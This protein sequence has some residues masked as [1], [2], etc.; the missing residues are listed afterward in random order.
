MSDA[1]RSEWTKLT[2]LRSTPWSLVAVVFVTVGLSGLITLGTH[3]DG[4]PG[5]NVACDDDLVELALSGVYLGQ[6]AAATLG[7]LAIGAEFSSGMIRATFA[8]T[9][10]RGHVLMAKALVI[11]GLVLVAGL[12]SSLLAYVLGLAVL[13][14]NGYTPANGYPDPTFAEALRG[15]AGT[16]VY[17][18]ALALLGLGVGAILRRTAAALTTVFCLLW[19]P[20]IV[21][22]ILPMDLGLKIARFCPML[23]GLAIQSTVTRPDDIPIAPGAGLAVICGYAAVALLAGAWL[24][25]RRDA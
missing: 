9:P 21:V 11:G 15:V 2:A 18:A 14:A 23:A 1:L 7:V 17:L 6:M 10:R 12:L 22:S 13:D 16:G 5:G 3:T 8:A 24:L 25:G 19:V 4:C 20:L